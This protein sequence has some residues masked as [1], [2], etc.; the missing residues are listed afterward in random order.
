MENALNVGF[1]VV[2]NEPHSFLEA[3]QSPYSKQWEDAIKSEFRQLQKA[4]VFE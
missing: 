2:A 3:L 4:G 1:V